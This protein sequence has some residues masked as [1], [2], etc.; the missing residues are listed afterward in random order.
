MRN[1]TCQF[2]SL[3]FFN[4]NQIYQRVRFYN[5]GFEPKLTNFLSEFFCVPVP[6]QFYMYNTL[7][8]N[9]TSNFL[10]EFFVCQLILSA[11]SMNLKQLFWFGKMPLKELCKTNFKIALFCPDTLGR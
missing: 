10:I 3:T 5:V 6:V 9:P 11:S 2:V 4:V 8:L 1:S 7:A